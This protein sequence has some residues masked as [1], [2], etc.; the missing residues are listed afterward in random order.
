[1][2]PITTVEKI[3][4]ELES[5]GDSAENEGVLSSIIMDQ[6]NEDDVRR[7]CESQIVTDQER[8]A[9]VDAKTE[10]EKMVGSDAFRI[11]PGPESELKSLIHIDRSTDVVGDNGEVS[12]I[13]SNVKIGK[14]ATS[15]ALPFSSVSLVKVTSMMDEVCAIFPAAFNFALNKSVQNTLPFITIQP[16]FVAAISGEDLLSA[17]DDIMDLRPEGESFSFLSN[18]TVYVRA[19]WIETIRAWC[20]SHN[21]T[22]IPFY[23]MLVLRFRMSACE[24]FRDCQTPGVSN[25]IKSHLVQGQDD[26]PL[27][28]V[29]DE[30]CISDDKDAC[31]NIPVAHSKRKFLRESG[32]NLPTLLDAVASRAIALSNLQESKDKEDI[33]RM[34][35]PFVNAFLPES[36]YNQSASSLRHLMM[37]PINLVVHRLSAS[38]RSDD[39]TLASLDGALASSLAQIDNFLTREE[40]PKPVKASTE[41]SKPTT[42]EPVEPIVP[43]KE[44]VENPD[45]SVHEDPVKDEQEWIAG[46]SDS[47]PA[48]GPPTKKNSRKKRKKKV[49]YWLLFLA[50]PVLCA[51]PLYCFDRNAKVAMPSNQF[52]LWFRNQLPIP[53]WYHLTQ[54]RK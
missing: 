17:F 15:E 31:R 24:S 33:E 21:S 42:E 37:T 29:A 43:I 8:N 12:G 44:Q 28:A 35:M 23:I 14:E 27:L 40:T 16:S 2:V 51:Y 30:Q 6:E 48:N 9:A 47:I 32:A 7:R 1:M 53:Y 4:R 38:I 25:E 26:E 46:S 19:S 45:I 22:S 49:R 18:S 50:C 36:F 3:Y 10:T 11:Q 52:K 34:L 41:A 39:V 20:A 13:L 5:A 54:K